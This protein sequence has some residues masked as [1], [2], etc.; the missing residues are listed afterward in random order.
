VRL[1][2]TTRGLRALAVTMAGVALATVAGAAPAQAE[3]RWIGYD[4]G[5][6]GCTYISAYASGADPDGRL[7]Q[8]NNDCGVPV[9][10]NFHSATDCKVGCVESRVYT[11]GAG[12]RNVVYRSPLT[13]APPAQRLAMR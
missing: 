8:V 5:N 11:I 13:Q 10:F 3:W 2:S 6:H 9:N 4:S 1:T 12:A 7:L